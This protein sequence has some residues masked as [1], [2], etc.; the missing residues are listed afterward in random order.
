MLVFPR[1][2]L[3][4]APCVALLAFVA[5]A[6]STRTGFEGQEVDAGDAGSST[7]SS[8]GFKPAEDSGAVGADGCSEDAKLVYVLSF[9]GDLYS[10]APADK[11][12]KKVG[13]L[14]CGGSSGELVPISMAVD[15]K[16]TAWVNL[17]SEAGIPGTDRLYKV[18][19]KT[20]ECT[21]TNIVGNMGGMGFSLDEGTKDKET[22]YVM[23]SPPDD[24]GSFLNRV[25]MDDEKLVTIAP[26]TEQ[27]GLELTGTGE[28]KLYGF[29][30]DDVL[31]LAQIDK[32]AMTFSNRVSLTDVERPIA[33]LYAFS[34]WGGDFYFY[35]GVALTGADTS[36]VTRYRPS[37]DSI[38]NAYMEDIGFRIVG[39]GVS[40]CAPTSAPK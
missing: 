21:P 28:G 19:T 16:A 32:S 38:D 20:A 26:M 17:R 8:G 29:L 3:A 23:G 34:F 25:D 33:P 39:A 6:D 15:R 1:I 37:D 10:F 11:K 36:N 31:G 35:T 9:E 2:W 13:P 27:V 40:T 12:F 24:L 18:D 14:D 30:I 7:G 5:C 22:L 4:G